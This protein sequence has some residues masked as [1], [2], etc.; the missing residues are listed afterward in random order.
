MVTIA[1]AS[2]ATSAGVVAATAPALTA[3]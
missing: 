1:V 3:D 2:L